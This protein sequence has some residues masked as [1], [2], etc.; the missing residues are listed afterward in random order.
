MMVLPKINDKPKYSVVIPSTGKKVE[1]RPFLVREEKI[2]LLAM[3]SQ[4]PKQI[5]KAIG[6]TIQACITDDLNMNKL[7][8]FDIE[9]M[10]LQIRGKSVGERA[11]LLFKCQKKDCNE[12]TELVI[13]IDDV[14]IDI[15]SDAI[16]T[17]KITDEYSIKM[18]WPT[19]NSMINSGV[20]NQDLNATDMAFS[21][22]IQCM[23]AIQSEDD[24]WVIKDTPESEV[25][26]FLE[27]LTS[28]QY[29]KI[30]EYLETIPQL[31]HEVEWDC[32]C[33]E[34]NKITLKGLNDFF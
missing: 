9:Y 30:T 5:L 8:I 31:T 6:D 13:N 11:P 17:I 15:Q 12:Q 19:Y 21:V 20:V 1:Y 25:I 4:N 26:E 14:K 24:Q 2:L 27:S 33:G 3:E 22:V 28:D 32:N 34:H 29:R 16:K 18:K 10:F 7:T 23:E